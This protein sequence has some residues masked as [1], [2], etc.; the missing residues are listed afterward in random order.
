MGG[1]F[2]SVENNAAKDDRG[3]TKEVTKRK[4]SKEVASIKEAYYQNEIRMYHNQKSNHSTYKGPYMIIE[5]HK[6]ELY[7]IIDASDHSLIQTEKGSNLFERIGA[8]QRKHLQEET[9][10]WRLEPRME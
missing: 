3:R 10:G 4:E 1:R 2:T 7:K 5:G 8:L 6:G 9:S